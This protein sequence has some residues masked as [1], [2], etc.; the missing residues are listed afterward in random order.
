VTVPDADTDTSRGFF[1]ADADPLT[2]T[3]PF[4]ADTDGGG[5]A[6]GA[7]DRNADGMVTAPETDPLSPSDDASCGAGAPGEIADVPGDYLKVRLSGGDIILEWGDAGAENPCILY[8]VYASERADAACGTG[9]EPL[10]TTGLPSYTHVGAA[11]LPAEA[12]DHPGTPAPPPA[13][14]RARRPVR[15]CR[16]CA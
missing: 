16:H 5:V 10:A 8:R 14:R 1:R 15:R 6:D 3:D 2:T 11:A 12:R 9:F 13:D 4:R 7:E